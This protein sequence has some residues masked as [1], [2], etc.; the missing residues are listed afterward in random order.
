MAHIAA[1]VVARALGGVCD[2]GGS[3]SAGTI[4]SDIAA[5]PFKLPIRSG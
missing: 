5:G 1:R 2:N 3:S 4:V